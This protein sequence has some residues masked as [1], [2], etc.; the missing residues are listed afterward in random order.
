MRAAAW[1]GPSFAFHA[2]MTIRSRTFHAALVLAMLAAKGAGAQSPLG[3]VSGT[4]SLP[5]PDGQPVV[6]PGVT[7]TLTCGLVNCNE[8]SNEQGQ[9]RFADATRFRRSSP[10]CRVQPVKAIVAV[11]DET[12]DVA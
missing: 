9:F 6:V 2:I 7:L 11:P 12:T 8:L 1:N 5:A 3:V 10:N 4:V